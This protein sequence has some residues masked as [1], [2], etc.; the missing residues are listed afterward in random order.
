MP[1]A[2]WED[3]SNFQT[4]NKK[5][6]VL[7]ILDPSFGRIFMDSSLQS[8]LSSRYISTANKSLSIKSC[9]A[10][11]SLQK[12]YAFEMRLNNRVW[13]VNTGAERGKIMLTRGAIMTNIASSGTFLASK[14]TKWGN[15]G[16]TTA[17]SVCLLQSLWVLLPMYWIDNEMLDTLITLINYIIFIIDYLL[18]F[19][20]LSLG[21]NSQ[22]VN[23]TLSWKARHRVFQ[24]C[25]GK[26]ADLSRIPL[27]F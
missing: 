18:P 13:L 9:L 8:K 21:H 2:C 4:T 22:I 26:T 27:L 1:V 17:L 16:Q 25:T 23:L 10:L 6:C 7:L 11:A 14:R 24:V 5:K 3:F 15:Q 20:L 19:D 12:Y